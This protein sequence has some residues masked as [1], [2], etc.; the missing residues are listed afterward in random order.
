M[1]DS[2][3]NA[4]LSLLNDDAMDRLLDILADSEDETTV[5]EDFSRFI[6]NQTQNI[7]KQKISIAIEDDII[8]VLNDDKIINNSLM[9]GLMVQATIAENIKSFKNTPMLQHLSGLNK[10]GYNK[11]LDNIAQELI[12]KYF[13]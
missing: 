13:E 2:K 3:I 1:K 8:K 4:C 6:D 9:L 10:E 7:V 5:K 12:N 11:L